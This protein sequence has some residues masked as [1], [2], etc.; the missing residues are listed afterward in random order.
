M[1]V[2]NLINSFQFNWRH[3]RKL[4]LHQ[5]CE[6]EWSTFCDNDCVISP[7]KLKNYV[8]S[9]LKKVSLDLNKE[10]YPNIHFNLCRYNRK[11][12]C[13]LRDTKV[14][15]NLTVCWNGEIYKNLTVSIDLTPA[16]PVVISEQ[17]MRDVNEHAWKELADRSFHVVPYLKPGESK[18]WRAS[19]S[20]NEVRIVRNLTKKQ[21]SLYKCLK[22]LRDLHG[23]VLAHIPSYHLK[24]FLLTT[25]YQNPDEQNVELIERENFY[26]SASWIIL[27]LKQIAEYPFNERRIEHFFLKFRMSLVNYD[28]RWC[29]SIL[30][31]LKSSWASGGAKRQLRRDMQNAQSVAYRQG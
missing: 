29:A 28:M 13:F 14:G 11:L 8:S 24:T 15:V 6:T 1:K 23:N 3:L 12:N 4:I 27:L 10:K 17:Q 26:S 5:K 16:I 19:F 30:E 7:R 21:I 22:F 25:L 9:L 20:L 2:V 18:A 31:H